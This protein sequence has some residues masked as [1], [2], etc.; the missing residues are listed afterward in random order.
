MK[1]KR[2]GNKR[3]L[4]I[5]LAKVKLLDQILE[6]LLEGGVMRSALIDGKSEA[7]ILAA[8]VPMFASRYAMSR[9]KAGNKV[10]LSLVDAGKVESVISLVK[11]IWKE[12]PAGGII[13]TLPVY[14]VRGTTE[15]EQGEEEHERD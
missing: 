8:D 13:F 1:D 7:G 15:L 2:D 9:A 12:D 5:V 10:I 6:A 3:L 11:D 14:N 4:V